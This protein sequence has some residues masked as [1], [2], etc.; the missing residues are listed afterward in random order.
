MPHPRPPQPDGGSAPGPV[1]N[2]RAPLVAGLLLVLA[3]LLATGGLRAARGLPFWPHLPG[4]G[5]R[6][7]RPVAIEVGFAWPEYPAR[8]RSTDPQLLS[9][10][11]R[12]LLA[13]RAA[14]PRRGER[15][16]SES[17][18]DPHFAYWTL[19][20]VD[21][22]GRRHVLFISAGGRFHD[23]HY[24]PLPR[25]GDLWEAVRP[26]LARLE[27]RFFGEPVPWERVDRLWARDAV[28]VI[29]DLESG[30]RFRVSRFGG[31]QHAD[32]EPV[33]PA[34]TAV[35]R[36]LYGGAWSWRR[37]A[38]VLELG[39]RR[40][41]A[42]INGMPHGEGVIADNDFPGHFCV[43]TLRS[44]THGGDRVD[45]AH[46][47]MILKSSGRLVRALRDAAPHQVVGYLL[48]A[49]AN[50][51]VA[52]AAH[53]VTDPGTGTWQ[54]ESA[55]LARGLVFVELGPAKTVSIDP[56]GREARVE[57]QVDAWYSDGAEGGH[58]R[59]HLVW[60]LARRSG[61]WTVPAEQ[62]RELRPGG[63]QATLAPPAIFRECLGWRGR[64]ESGLR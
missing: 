62:L 61:F 23:P 14:A 54:E 64:E 20:L 2:R 63:A 5:G 53:M 44:T 11:Y 35:L 15:L 60:R 34:D 39:E 45:P 47:L 41:A 52:T 46:H 28:A 36:S 27:E 43:H 21:R 40:I 50:G 7:S 17:Q 10:I 42:S 8:L 33:T 1:R 19:T 56:A 32:A 25:A 29:R 30:R 37:R 57:V 59:H 13:A 55:R 26:L 16:A 12:A 9:R 3:A 51:D 4:L 58:G 38:V 6:A 48:V 49:L 24:G 22:A 31:T 18:P